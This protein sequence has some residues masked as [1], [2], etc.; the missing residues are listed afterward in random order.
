[1]PPESWCGYLRSAPARPDQVDAAAH[2]L[3]ARFL[4][5]ALAGGPVREPEADVALDGLPREQ[6]VVLEHHAAL[7]RRA[8]DRP[9]VDRDAPGRRRLEAGE[10]VQHGRLAAARRADD[11]EELA[12]PHVE[13]QVLDRDGRPVAVRVEAL[14]DALDDELRAR[15]SPA[16]RHRERQ[17]AADQPVERDT[18]RARPRSCTRRCG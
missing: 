5:H 9:P 1:M 2:A 4:R 14:A 18:R 8:G 10:Q 15:S 17:R 7:G 11:R 6:R 13:R 16:P 3:G 12:L